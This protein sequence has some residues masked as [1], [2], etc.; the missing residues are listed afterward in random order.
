MHIFQMTELIFATLHLEELWD[1]R[2]ADSTYHNVRRPH[3]VHLDYCWRPCSA[4]SILIAVNRVFIARGSSLSELVP[5]GMDTV[6][7]AS[8]SAGSIRAGARIFLRRFG[9]TA[10]TIDSARIDNS[11]KFRISGQV[12][13]LLL[14]Q[15]YSELVWLRG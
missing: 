11:A 6:L 9:N 3:V 4:I 10:M 2:P 7:F 14:F 13:A 5:A 15:G 8:A 1:K 12:W